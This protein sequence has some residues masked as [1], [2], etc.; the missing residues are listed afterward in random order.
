MQSDSL[1]HQ[2][3]LVG[4]LRGVASDK[5]VEVAKVLYTAGFR[6]IEVPLNSPQPFASIS[7]LA[8]MLPADCLVGAG[9]V[10]T[11]QDVQRTHAAG[12]RLAVAPNCDEQV[13]REAVKL[14]MRVMPGIATAT[15]AFSAARAGATL[16]K[17]FPASTYGPQHLRALCTVLPKEIKIFPVGGVTAEQIP[18]WRAAGAAGFGFGSELFRPEY[19]LDEIKSRAQLLVRAYLADSTTT[20]RTQSGETP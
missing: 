13:I 8:G 16:L 20:T 7:A 6:V 17:L 4:I 9:T 11:P 2:D 12:G 3:A 10:L 19:S 5:V 18:G 1:P 15:E 14:G